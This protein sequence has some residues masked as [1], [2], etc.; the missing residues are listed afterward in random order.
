M[1]LVIVRGGGIGGPVTLTELD[2]DQL[3]S[4]DSQ[5]LAEQV[6][7]ADLGN[8]PE[9]ATR[10]RQPDEL[11]YEIVVHNGGER[12]ILRFSEATLPD[13][14]RLLIQWIDGRPERSQS[15]APR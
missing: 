11:L 2:S 14:I 5:A 12:L 1:K 7:R 6:D 10:R 3:S 15:L 8:V 4:A 9:P 13:E